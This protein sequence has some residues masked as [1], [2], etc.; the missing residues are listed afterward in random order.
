MVEI[1]CGDF[2]YS[3]RVLPVEVTCYASAAELTKAAEPVMAHH[4]PT[5]QDCPSFKACLFHLSI[6]PERQIQA[7]WIG[8]EAIRISGS[9]V[10]RIA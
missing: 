8:S 5:G 3:M 10:I 7:I 2:R 1:L 9:E 6:Y 4:F